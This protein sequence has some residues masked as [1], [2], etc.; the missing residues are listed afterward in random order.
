MIF[1]VLFGMDS[2]AWAQGQPI[3]FSVTGDVPYGKSE[4]LMFQQQAANHNKYSASAFFVHVGDIFLGGCD[5]SKYSQMASMMK[6][7]AVPAYIVP[8][9]HE[10]IDCRSPVQGMSYFL[11]YFKNFEQNFCDAPVTKH[12]SGRPE[13]WTFTSNGVLFIGVNFVYGNSSV[14]EQAAD[15]VQQQLEA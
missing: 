5:E 13:N 3:T 15:W 7:L 2:R 8:G 9:N 14:V 10:T 12:Q 4:T 11:K 6:G 1:A